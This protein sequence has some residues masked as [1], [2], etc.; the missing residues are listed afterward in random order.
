V[1]EPGKASAREPAS[2]R[3]MGSEALALSQQLCHQVNYDAVAL[4]CGHNAAAAAVSAP[5][6]GKRTLHGPMRCPSMPQ[7]RLAPGEPGLANSPSCDHLWAGWP[8]TGDLFSSESKIGVSPAPPSR[9]LAR[10]QAGI[11]Y[12]VSQKS[13]QGTSAST[14]YVEMA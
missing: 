4:G 12:H 1:S 6:A 10:F 9:L 7:R 13:M 3:H 11:D 2:V 8:G 5:N 14:S